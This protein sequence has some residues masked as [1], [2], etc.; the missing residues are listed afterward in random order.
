ML[1]SWASNFWRTRTTLKLD[2]SWKDLWKTDWPEL[3]INI[4]LSHIPLNCADG[5]CREYR[6]WRQKANHWKNL[7]FLNTSLGTEWSSMK[8]MKSLQIDT[9]QVRRSRLLFELWPSCVLQPP[10]QCTMQST[11]GM[12][13]ELLFQI[14][15]LLKNCVVCWDWEWL[16]RDC[17]KGVL[18][19]LEIPDPRPH[20]LY[21]SSC[22]SSTQC[23]QLATD[24]HSL[25][26]SLLEK[27][28]GKYQRWISDSSCCGRVGN[29][30]I[31]RHWESTL[32]RSWKGFRYFTPLSTS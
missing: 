19:Y 32:S 8:V 2:P 13:L 30:W 6:N 3:L 22:I 14:C 23:L 7:L 18:N 16:Y 28:K 27:H 12:S 25:E 17:L 26:Q 31:H 24:W 15:K 9:T 1:W 4:M 29:G 5:V 21:L 10:L 20:T 11:I